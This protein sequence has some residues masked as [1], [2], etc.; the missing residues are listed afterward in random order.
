MTDS[1]PDNSPV[2]I[3]EPPFS[4]GAALREGRIRLGLS[5]ADVASHLKFAPRQIEALEA[6]DFAHLPEITFVRGFVRSYAR[7]L[8]LDSAPL[9][10]A[11]PGAQVQPAPLSANVQI[12]V[13][14]PSDSS[15]R[16][17]N[18]IWLAAALVVAA[19]VGL[20]AWLHGNNSN[21]PRA[22]RTEQ[23]RAVPARLTASAVPDLATPEPEPV[24]ITP[25]QVAASAVQQAAPSPAKA[26]VPAGKRLRMEFDEES[27]VEVK[28]RDD[29]VL[30]SQVFPRGSVQGLNGKAPFSLVIGHSSAVRLYYKDKPVDLAP[31]TKADVAHLT[32]E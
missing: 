16:R 1:Q 13:P 14:F 17:L 7:L 18:I 29:R 8:Q 23:Q 24:M 25:P 30:L 32:L 21:A 31:Y 20:F 10:A 22:P 6:D 26:V 11:L 19:A 12:E 2:N 27:W 4:V 5:V 9:L 3:G 15:A 28:D